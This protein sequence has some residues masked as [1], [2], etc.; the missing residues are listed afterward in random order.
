MR[1]E[2][3]KSGRWRKEICTRRREGGEWEGEKAA[4]MNAHEH[5]RRQNLQPEHVGQWGIG[6]KEK[7]H[8]N[9]GMR[10]GW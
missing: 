9:R 2:G 8:E 7:R 1:G 4:C 6:R 3:R 5:A 10:G